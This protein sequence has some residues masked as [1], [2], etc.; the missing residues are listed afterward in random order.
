MIK[1]EN[2]CVDCGMPCFSSC[3]YKNVM[4]MY[5]DRCGEEVDEL[6]ETHG[7]QLCNDCMEENEDEL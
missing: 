5:C 3:R 6:N 4:R 7:E 1:Y 2:E